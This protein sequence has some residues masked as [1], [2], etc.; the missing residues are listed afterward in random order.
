MSWLQLDPALLRIGLFI[1]VDYGWMEHPFVRNSFLIS[2]PSEIS[3]IQKHQLTKLLYDPG[4]SHADALAAM[5][6][7]A[8]EVSPKLGENLS[9]ASE[10]DE[11]AIQKEKAFHIQRASEYRTALDEAERTYADMTKRC[12]ILT[13]MANTGHA[14][15]VQLANQIVTDMLALLVQPSAALLI[16]QGE[17]FDD[18]ETALAAQTMNVSAIAMLT[19][20]FMGLNWPQLQRLSLSVLFHKLG[21]EI[22]EAVPD[23][24]PEVV[25]IVYQHRDYLGESNSPKGLLNDDTVQLA[26]VVS[27]VAKYNQL[28]S[29]R[30]N[31]KHISQTQALSHLYVNLRHRFGSDVIDSFIATMTVYPPGSFL[32]MSDGTIGLVVKTNPL[33]RM[34]PIIKFHDPGASKKETPVIDLSRE[35]SLRIRKV[36][37]P[38]SVPKNI[39]NILSSG[40]TVGYAITVV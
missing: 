7:P 37:D 19:G 20:K 28:T 9:Q 32:E 36:L 40:Q 2:S 35:R 12:S 33:E 18:Q 15:G 8:S 4:R 11:K 21:K 25:D 6:K 27:T 24:P 1:R 17:E 23:M 39:M 22:L 31:R 13:T 26:R 3:I 29:D 34:R 10:E 38:K 14:E 16:V 5:A 30:R